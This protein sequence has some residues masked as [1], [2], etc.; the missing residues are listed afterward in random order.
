M[1]IFRSFSSICSFW[2][3]KWTFDTLCDSP[4]KVRQTPNALVLIQSIRRWSSL[5]SG[6]INQGLNSASSFPL[7]KTFL[8]IDFLFSFL[9]LLFLLSWPWHLSCSSTRCL[10]ITEKVSFNITSEASYVYILNGQ[11]L[12]KNAKKWSIL[13]SF[14][15]PEAYGQTVLPDRSVLIGQKLVENAKIQMR[16]F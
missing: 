2:T 4:V 14:W 16:H 15:K 5:L 13:A 12:I 8:F 10:K 6:Y 9:L 1:T 11:K 7:A 3:K